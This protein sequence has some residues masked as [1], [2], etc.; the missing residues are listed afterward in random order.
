MSGVSTKVSVLDAA[1]PAIEHM[2]RGVSQLISGMYKLNKATNNAID[3]TPFLEAQKSMAE[4]VAVQKQLANGMDNVS[5]EYRQVKEYTEQANNA[6]Q[7]YNRSLSSGINSA[8]AFGDRLTSG[9]KRYI[10]MAAGAYGGK[11]LIG[12]SDTWTNNSA[13]LGLITDN[14]QK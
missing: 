2:Y 11:K 9:I 12:E 8:T 4:A 10:T 3:M 7:R 1:T 13:R 5:E 14:L 6:Q